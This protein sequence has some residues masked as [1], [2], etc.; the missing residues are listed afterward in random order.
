MNVASLVKHD[1]L[2]SELHSIKRCPLAFCQS[3]I[4]SIT[5]ET[6]LDPVDDPNKLRDH[7]TNCFDPFFI[8]STDVVY[9][10]PQLDAST[11]TYGRTKESLLFE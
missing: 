7:C 9:Q 10:Y 1:Q 8:E 5:A 6:V 4:L 11:V 3:T 2:S